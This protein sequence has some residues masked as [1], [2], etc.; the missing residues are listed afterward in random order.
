MIYFVAKST[1]Q[2]PHTLL[3]PSDWLVELSGWIAMELFE[4]QRWCCRLSEL[5]DDTAI[6]ALD[7]DQQLYPNIDWT[8]PLAVTRLEFECVTLT[9]LP[10]DIAWSEPT[11]SDIDLLRGQLPRLKT[12]FSKT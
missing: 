5:V 8:P 3:L 11:K 2:N 6:H 1:L 12:L 4:T 7:P 9:Q 10:T